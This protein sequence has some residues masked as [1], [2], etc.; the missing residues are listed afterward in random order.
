MKVNQLKALLKLCEKAP[1]YSD[2]MEVVIDCHDRP[3]NP[4]HVYLDNRWSGKNHP[5]N[6]AWMIII[7]TE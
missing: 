3:H 6:D 7:D 5:Q 4:I 2:D 1:N